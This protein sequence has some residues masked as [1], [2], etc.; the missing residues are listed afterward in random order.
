MG[1]R[2][3]ATRVGLAVGRAVSV[4]GHEMKI[5]DHTH[6]HTHPP[7]WSRPISG[8]RKGFYTPQARFDCYQ[9]EP[10]ASRAWVSTLLPF[11]K[12]GHDVHP[13][14]RLGR[15]ELGVGSEVSIVEVT[16]VCPHI[17]AR[18]YDVPC[19]PPACRTQLSCMVTG[20][21]LRV[22]VT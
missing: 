11:P 8:K 17:R 3:G 5:S 9:D 14:V 7:H 20:K 12:P 4:I 13:P 18:S 10:A 1:V 6:I 2:D 22:F 21:T 16:P 19:C 15:T